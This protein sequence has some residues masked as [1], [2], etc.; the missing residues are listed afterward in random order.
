MVSRRS[1]LG[2]TGAATLAGG[3]P[4]K[5]LSDELASRSSGASRPRIAIITTVWRYLSHAQHMGDRFLVGYPHEGVE[6]RLRG[7]GEPDQGV[8]EIKCPALMN[9]YHNRPD[10][11]S[12]MT[13][14]GFNITGDVFRRDDDGFY[15][16]VGRSD[17]S[18]YLM[19]EH[20][21]GSGELTVLLA[22]LL[23][24]HAGPEIV[25]SRIA[26]VIRM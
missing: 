14:D 16:F 4:V 15:Y 8:L 9:G 1:F 3:L 20:V 19:V 22:S 10:L 12:P 24:A 5:S 11:P 25:E 17:F 21:A 26:H 7:E 13:P 18:E 23:G 6:L 2:V